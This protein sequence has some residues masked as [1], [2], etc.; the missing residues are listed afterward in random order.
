[1]K[2][3]FINGASCAGKSTILKEIMK[4]RPHTFHLSFDAIKWMF[5]DY[6]RATHKD[7]VGKLFFAME[8]TIL[9]LE[10]DI[11]CESGVWREHREKILKLAQ[12]HG[13][14]TIEINLEADKLVLEERFKERVNI[15]KIHKLK[16]ANT[17]IDR[18][19]ELW[20]IYRNEKNEEAITYRTDLLSL[21]EI[22]SDILK[23]F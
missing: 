13:Y 17:S 11:L 6:N 9:N 18:F 20:E 4:Q 14:E 1:M 12:E 16:M 19:N 21:D 15:G 23:K 2:L 22:V 10:Y 3:L 5:S 7:D 8:E